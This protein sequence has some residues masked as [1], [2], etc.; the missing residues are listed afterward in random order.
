VHGVEVFEVALPVKSLNRTEEIMRRAILLFLLFL[1]PGAFG[2]SNYAV[3]SGT[4]TDPQQGPVA[5]AAVALT[6][7]ETH[8]ERRV[9]TNAQ[10]IFQITGIQLSARLSL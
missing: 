6:S 4:V 9:S 1:T 2:Q 7:N 5:G 8:T 3:I 10:G